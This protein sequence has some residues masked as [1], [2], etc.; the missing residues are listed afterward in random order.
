MLSSHCQPVIVDKIMIAHTN[1][2]DL[3]VAAAGLSNFHIWVVVVG[4]VLG[5]L[6]SD[7]QGLF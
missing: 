1:T 5:V 2:S 6:A 3:K 7:S 4:Q